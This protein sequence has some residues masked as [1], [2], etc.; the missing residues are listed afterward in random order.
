MR[1]D[2]R[3]TGMN[4]HGESD[5]GMQLDIALGPQK[6]DEDESMSPLELFAASLGMCVAAMLRNHCD[7]RELECG[8]IKVT[9]ESEW[10]PGEPI[11]ENI[12]VTV[13]VDGEWDER[14]KAA[15]LKVA[16]T[17]PVHQSIVSCGGVN[18]E[19]V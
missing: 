8:E 7:E 19:I 11:C 9:V 14:R 18:I 16:E 10:D 4:Y 1:I 13:V 5:R 15:F 12:E 2:V 6:P 3:N 17:C